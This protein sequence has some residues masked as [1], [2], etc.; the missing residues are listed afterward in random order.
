ME[1]VSSLMVN[2]VIWIGGGVLT[3]IVGLVAYF[4]FI[5]KNQMRGM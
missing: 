5:S 3:L 2:A 4:V 1:A